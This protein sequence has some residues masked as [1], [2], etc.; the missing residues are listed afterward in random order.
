MGAGGRGSLRGI[1]NMGRGWAWISVGRSGGRS[2]SGISWLWVRRIR[3]R[4]RVVVGG[5]VVVLVSRSMVVAAQHTRRNP[6]L[7]LSQL[8]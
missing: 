5:I 6:T 1:R 4:G 3:G 7:H 2:M 8:P